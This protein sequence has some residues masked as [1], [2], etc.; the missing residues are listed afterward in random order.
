MGIYNL[1]PQV[2]FFKLSV[3]LSISKF[4]DIY[5]LAPQANFLSSV[6]HWLKDFNGFSLI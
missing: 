3:N 5:Y 4:M 6:C 2:I 1:A